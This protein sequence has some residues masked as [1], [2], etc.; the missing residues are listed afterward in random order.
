[1]APS[2]PE[3]PVVVP[4]DPRWAAQAAE[5]IAELRPV[6]GPPAVRVA[7]IGSTAIP[8]MAAK[9][10]LDLQV[11][12]RELRELREP[13]GSGL[14]AMGFVRLPYERD[15]VPAYLNDDPSRWAKRF[16]KRRGGPG[17]D[18]NLHVRV[19][20]SPNERLALLFR[21]WFRAHPGAVAA[22]AR[23]KERLAGVV[24]DVETYAD[25]KDPVVDLVISVAE[26]WA[27]DTGW[28]VEATDRFGA[29]G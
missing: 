14:P 5:L 28:T 21:D 12:V 7:H 18:V 22:Y 27:E 17:A 25:V 6:L 23:F 3:R 16:W 2:E 15:H 9:P 20:G 29:R 24:G 26:A 13:F 19:C 10:V 4:A 1:M 8:G 11:S